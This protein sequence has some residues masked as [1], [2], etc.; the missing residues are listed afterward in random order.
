MIVC[1]L[2]PRFKLTVAAG[3][4]EAL[5][6]GPLA[7]APEPGGEPLVGEVSAAAEG[8]GIH[9]GMRVG[10]ALARCP[11]LRL[12]TAD[13][14]GVEEVWEELLE[15]LEAI[16]SRVAPERPGSVCFE[17]DG[18]LGLHGGQLERLIAVVRRT[19]RRPARIGAGP[20]R[21]CA[22]AAASA[23]RAGRP[24]LIEGGEQAARAFL[25]D[26]PV[27]LL[28]L[29]AGTIT[30][31]DA[32]ERLGIR[33]LGELAALRRDAVADRLGPAGLLGHALAHGRDGR[34]VARQ[35]V[36][37]LEESLELPESAL[38]EQL[39]RALELLIDRL[40]ARRERRGRTLR[41]VVLAAALVQ[42]GTWRQRVSLRQASDDSQR[43]RLAVLPR[44]ALLPAPAERLRLTAERFGPPGGDQRSLLEE[45]IAAR[46]RRLREAIRHTRAAAG[47]D[48][49]LRVLMVDPN[50][51][52]PERRAV[53]APFEA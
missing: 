44:L 4:R 17:A 6:E 22:L 13:P 15:R 52:V 11:Q 51:R 50:S 20:T 29:R 9:C 53:L 19:L 48:A 39:E 31:P 5:L 24:L 33:T 10:E 23:A 28:R 1:V 26:Q 21:F 14:I 38:G 32:L 45:P 41:V 8:F 49:A 18:L 42:G 3:G 46:A 34:L 37:R 47:P 25:A 40:L 2:F 12:V 7:V 27:E 35:P 43:I 30:L 36:E 16:G